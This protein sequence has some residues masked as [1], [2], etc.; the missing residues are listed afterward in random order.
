MALILKNRV[1][2]T[3]NTTGTADVVLAG[4]KSGMQTFSSVMADNDT[5]Y[6]SLANGT[7][8]ELGLGT[9]SSASN[10]YS[11]G[12]VDMSPTNATIY[13]YP[14]GTSGLSTTESPYS[15]AGTGSMYFSATNTSYLLFPLGHFLGNYTEWTLQFWLKPLGTLTTDVNFPIFP[16]GM[17]SSNY[18]SLGPWNFNYSSALFSFRGYTATYF[19]YNNHFNVSGH[20]PDANAWNHYAVT[21]DSNGL[22]RIL[23][24]GSPYGNGT[25]DGRMMT[26]S[27]GSG[28]MQMGNSPTI[29]ASGSAPHNYYIS[30]FRITNVVESITAAPTAPLGVDSNTKFYL[31]FFTGWPVQTLARTTVLESSDSSNA[32]V[33]LPTGPTD[34]FIA[35]PAQ[36]I[37]STD[38]ASSGGGVT[39]HADNAALITAGASATNGDLAYVTGTA[40][41]FLYNSGWYK[42]SGVNQTPTISAPNTDTVL[43]TS[44]VTH[45]E[46]ITATDPD[47]FDTLQ[48]STSIAGATNA[49]TISQGTGAS[50][51]VFTFTATTISTNGGTATVTYNV[52]DGINT[53]QLIKPYSVE[54]SMNLLRHSSGFTGSTASGLSWN[55][56]RFGSGSDWIYMYAGGSFSDFTTPYTQSGGMAVTATEESFDTAAAIYTYSK[57]NFSTGAFDYNN[58]E[59][60]FHLSRL[61]HINSTPGVS[62]WTRVNGTTSE[63]AA[64]NFG[65]DNIAGNGFQLDTDSIWFSILWMPDPYDHIIYLGLS[66]EQS[67]FKFLAVDKGVAARFVYDH[68]ANINNRVTVSLHGGSYSTGT[69][70]SV[71][72]QNVVTQVYKTN[73]TWNNGYPWYR[74]AIRAKLGRGSRS[75]TIKVPVAVGI[76]SYKDP[77]DSIHD[78]GNFARWQVAKSATAEASSYTYHN[79]TTSIVV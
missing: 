59:Y 76:M 17:D 55:Y 47:N 46:T 75:S 20:A 50:S 2:E 40:A 9:Y 4:A 54:F 15:E 35:L 57:Y 78:N 6:Y 43:L 41:L 51:N 79:T 70:T 23:K 77:N 66:G 73:A 49:V 24:N 36:K 32:K 13:Y 61:G 64:V 42:I 62:L 71:N 48:Y 21:R 5:T 37:V 1:E 22:Y 25:A 63:H 58:G 39:T 65:T 26:S 33:T 28:N 74:I 16:E 11:T 7:T 3:T 34:V 60:N 14:D 31:P 12:L 8:W 68:T 69:S 45:T 56:G 67:P 38:T 72:F 19:G 52:T 44:G 30:D 29:A 18:G 27:F 53:A 10:P